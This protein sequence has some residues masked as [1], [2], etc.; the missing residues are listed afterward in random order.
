MAAEREED[1]GHRLSKNFSTAFPKDMVKNNFP[2]C[3][4]CSILAPQ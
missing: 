4:S 3:V 1:P 2:T